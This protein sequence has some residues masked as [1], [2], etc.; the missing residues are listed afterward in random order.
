MR[1]NPSWSLRCNEAELFAVLPCQSEHFPICQCTNIP[2][3]IAYQCLLFFFFPSF[4][5]DAHDGYIVQPLGSLL[6]SFPWNTAHISVTLHLSQLDSRDVS[7]P[8]FLPPVILV[9]V[10][11]PRLTHYQ[12][13]CPIDQRSCDLVWW[14][15]DFG[16]Q[17]WIFL[18]HSP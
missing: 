5:N 8:R 10:V 2:Y 16:E 11:M 9:H 1:D 17:R 12:I 7:F 6:I 4:L 15:L 13:H 3:A 14:R 18:T